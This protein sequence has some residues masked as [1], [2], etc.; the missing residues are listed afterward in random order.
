[1][2]KCI[3]FLKKILWNFR[4]QNITSADFFFFFYKLQRLQTIKGRKYLF[5]IFNNSLIQTFTIGNY[6]GLIPQL[7]FPIQNLLI[8]KNIFLLLTIH[9]KWLRISHKVASVMY[10]SK[11]LSYLMKSVSFILLHTQ[12]V[13]GMDVQH[14]HTSGLKKFLSCLKWVS[15]Q[16]NSRGSAWYSARPQIFVF[17]WLFI[18][19]TV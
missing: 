11:S 7:K 6:W 16:K 19:Q 9:E 13:L 10:F 5:A 3:E 12:K 17:Q 8:F 1:M 15:E 4:V 2:L 14:F 18:E